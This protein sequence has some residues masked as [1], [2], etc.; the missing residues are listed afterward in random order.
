MTA[1]Q[2]AWSNTN[3]KRVIDAPLYPSRTSSQL[4]HLLLVPR[5]AMRTGNECMLEDRGMVRRRAADVRRDDRR[6]AGGSAIVHAGIAGRRRRPALTATG[7]AIAPRAE[8]PSRV[9]DKPSH[10]PAG[11]DGARCRGRDKRTS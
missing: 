3:S 5:E 8:A 6:D 7:R 10:S 9:D 11:T 1:A 2:A 4:S